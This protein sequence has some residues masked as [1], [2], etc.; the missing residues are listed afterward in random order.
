MAKIY[1]F[2]HGFRMVLFYCLISN[3]TINYLFVIFLVGAFMLNF[4]IIHKNEIIANG[5]YVEDIGPNGKIFVIP[6]NL[7]RNNF[8]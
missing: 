1:N 6:K 4:E 8:V 5:N 7:E 3:K 2:N